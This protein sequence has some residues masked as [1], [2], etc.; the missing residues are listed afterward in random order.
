[1]TPTPFSEGCDAAS[2]N[3][4]TKFLVETD[5]GLSSTLK[6]FRVQPCRFLSAVT[7]LFSP[8]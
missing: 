2:S 4:R 6:A 1:M 8:F 7:W 5:F 3:D